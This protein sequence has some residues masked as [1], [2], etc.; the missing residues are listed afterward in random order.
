MAVKLRQY[1]LD[2]VADT[3]TAQS[4]Q[5]TGNFNN[6]NP[7]GTISPASYYHGHFSA[8][9]MP[10]PSS[11]NIGARNAFSTFINITLYGQIRALG[12]QPLQHRNNSREGSDHFGIRRDTNCAVRVRSGVL[13]NGMSD[14]LCLLADQL[15]YQHQ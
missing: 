15:Q 12:T 14:W 1:H 9:V 7:Y 5:Y 6:F 13:A 11:Q 8:S 10:L 2:G 4:F 3:M